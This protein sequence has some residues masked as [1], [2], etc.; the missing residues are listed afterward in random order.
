MRVLGGGEVGDSFPE[1]CVYGGG[2]LRLRPGHMG[3]R[4]KL[5]GHSSIAVDPVNT[6]DR[7][8]QV[9]PLGITPGAAIFNTA[10]TGPDPSS[11]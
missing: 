1:S 5:Y 11:P 7:A 4:F 6:Q 9:V 10:F 8:A 2:D 3:S